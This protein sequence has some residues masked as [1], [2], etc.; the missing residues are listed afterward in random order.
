MGCREV[1][2]PHSNLLPRICPGRGWQAR[3]GGGGTLCPSSWKDGTP[4]HHPFLE[5]ALMR[6][7]HR[8][9]LGSETSVTCVQ[10]WPRLAVSRLPLCFRDPA[11]GTPQ[12]RARIFLNEQGVHLDFQFHVLTGQPKTGDV[13]P[14]LTRLHCPHPSQSPGAALLGKAVSREQFSGSERSAPSYQPESPCSCVCQN[15]AL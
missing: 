5:L 3:E 8:R 6:W 4:R 14:G 7:L 9:G 10:G 13:T 12:L 2:R 15:V 1:Q 11:M